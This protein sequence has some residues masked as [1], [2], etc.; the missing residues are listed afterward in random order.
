MSGIA[1]NLLQPVNTGAQVQQGF[2]TG[3]AMVKQM[4]TRSALGSYLSNPDDPQAFGALAYLDP[5]AAEG[6][7]RQHLLR[8]KAALEQEALQAQRA[9]GAQAASGDIAGARQ[10]ALQG[11]QFELAEQIAKLDDESLERAGAFWEKAGPLAFELKQIR[12]PQ[13]RIARYQAAKPILAATGADQRLIESFDPTNDMALDAAVTTA[14]TVADRIQ[15]SRVT[16]HQQG[17]QPSFAT[18]YMGRP[19]GSQN[20]YAQGAGAPAPAASGAPSA[21]ASTL[22]TALPAPVVAGF[23]GNFEAEGG[24]GG[25]KGDGGTAAGIAQWRGER[26]TNFQRVIGKP[27]SE[28]TPEEQARFVLWEMQNPQA[29]GMTIE[30]RDA[31]LNARTPA[32][33]AALID[34]HYERSDGRHRQKRVA[35]AERFAGGGPVR[36]ASKAEFDKL[37]SG[38]PFIA[39][40]GSVRR[41]P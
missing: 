12:D 36:V 17:E 9:V 27:V 15:Q 32:E 37:P 14:Q 1:W 40:D 22:A 41:K 2:A 16:W 26:Q 29:A 23:L 3:A 30:Q 21:V 19:V 7:Q 24:Y 6:A 39:P 8:R 13:E 38:T 4:Q 35:A 25:G 18:D 11:G 20:P 33:A 28:A 34:Q 5:Q 10:T 31:I